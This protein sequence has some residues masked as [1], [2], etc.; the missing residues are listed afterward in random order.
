MVTGWGGGATRGGAKDYAAV[1]FSNLVATVCQYE[2]LKYLTYSVST[3]AKTMKVVP[4]MIWGQFLGEKK[5]TSREYFDAAVMTF[6]C[7]VFVANRGWRSAVQ[8]RYEGEYDES[9][10][11]W[12]ANAGFLILAVY[13]VFDGFTS[14]FQQKMYRRDGVTVTAQVFFTSFFTT[15]FGFAWLVITDQLSPSIRFVHDHPAIVGDILL[16]SC[17]ST[18][19]QFSIAY[20]IK[21]YSAVILAS[22]MTFRQFLSVLISCYVFSSPLNV[23]QWLGISL[24]LAPLT[25][26]RVAFANR[27]ESAHPS[28]SKSDDDRSERP[29]IH[30]RS[31]PRSPRFARVAV[32]IARVR[33]SPGV[34]ARASPSRVASLGAA[35]LNPT[36]AAVGATSI[37][38]VATR[39]VARR[40]ACPSPRGPSRATPRPRSPRATPSSRSTT[41]RAPRSPN[42]GR[43]AAKICS[44]ARFSARSSARCATT[45]SRDG[46]KRARCRRRSTR[47]RWSGRTRRRGTKRRRRRA[48]APRRGRERRRRRR[49]RRSRSGSK[50]GANARE[51]SARACG[52]WSAEDDGGA[53]VR[54]GVRCDGGRDVRGAGTAAVVGDFERVV[55]S[56]SAGV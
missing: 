51:R 2:V 15:V 43:S 4:V 8:K 22:I 3:L 13:F 44:S 9:S 27:A 48:R 55:Q 53:G 54:A 52:G 20:T 41:P 19:A 21:S 33:S 25:F 26:K 37:V 1:S 50:E 14:T 31:R 6:G 16:L 7:F 30:A 28:S 45:R 12:A 49:R 47:A 38:I 42:C 10:L 23:V 5:F 17:A 40:R 32:A 46:A 35:T 56:A 29:V 18:V 24:I 34:V 11:E 36:F 39:R